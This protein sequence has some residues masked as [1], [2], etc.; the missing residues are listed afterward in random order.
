MGRYNCPDYNNSNRPF[1][2]DVRIEI[3]FQTR[4][5][6]RAVDRLLEERHVPCHTSR[7]KCDVLVY[8]ERLFGLFED[9]LKGSLACIDVS[10]DGR[11]KRCF[12][13]LEI[14]DPLKSVGSDGFISLDIL[15]TVD[16]MGSSGFIFTDAL[17]C[18]A[19]I[20]SSSSFIVLNIF[21]CSLDVSSSSGF[22]MLDILLCALDT[23]GHS[24]IGFLIAIINALLYGYAKSQ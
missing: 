2:V 16:I 4:V 21:L 6:R 1:N 19:K 22:T 14:L 3:N 12:I 10:V 8:M 17:P 5:Q 15:C 7:A 24:C 11:F 20:I 13:F 18:V 9:L 23:I